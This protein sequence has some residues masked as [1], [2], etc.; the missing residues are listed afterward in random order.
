[1]A[2]ALSPPSRTGGSGTF[3][4]AM[5]NVRSGRQGGLENALRAMDSLGVDLGVLQETK[6]TGG[7]YS[8]YSKGYNVLATDAPSAWKGGVA[9]FWREG[10]LFEVEEQQNRGP[11]VITFELVTGKERF[12]VV[13]AYI[14]RRP[15][16]QPLPM[17]RMHGVNA[18][19]GAN[20]CL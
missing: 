18:R 15:T 5:Y 7:I 3:R 12:F 9:L 1:M 20:H 13:G 8:K 6:L 4:V 17:L 10:D 16:P 2:T 11:N 14:F 19:K